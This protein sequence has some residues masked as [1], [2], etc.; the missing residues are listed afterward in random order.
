MFLKTILLDR[1]ASDSVKSYKQLIWSN[2]YFFVFVPK[3]KFVCLNSE[4]L[5]KKSLFWVEYFYQYTD[6]RAKIKT[7]NIWGWFG[8]VLNSCKKTEYVAILTLIVTSK[9]SPLQNVPYLYQG[10]QNNFLKEEME[11]SR[12][13]RKLFL[14]L[15]G[16]S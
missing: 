1:W 14:P 11:L 6:I 5:Y 16:L 13:E 4:N 15:P 12:Q 8:I 3:V 2:H 9:N 7:M 10:V